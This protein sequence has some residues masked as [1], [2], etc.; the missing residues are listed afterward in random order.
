MLTHVE[1][2]E[3]AAVQGEA[4]QRV[5]PLGHHLLVVVSRVDDR[6]EAVEI[7]GRGGGGLQAHRC[8]APL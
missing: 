1:G 3:I 2:V 4:G 5:D 6:H 7:R 8:V